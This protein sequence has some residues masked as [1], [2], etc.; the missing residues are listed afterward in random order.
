MIDSSR[1]Y[2]SPK[3]TLTRIHSG[4]RSRRPRPVPTPASAK[5]PRR[6]TVVSP[7]D[8]L[9][10]APAPPPRE[11]TL[12]SSGRTRHATS[13][14]VKVAPP[15]RA[16]RS[17]GDRVDDFVHR[18]VDALARERRDG[19]AAN[20]TRHDPVEVPHVGVDV[21]REAVHR[22]TAGQSH[23]DRRNLAGIIGL[24]VDPHAGIVAQATDVGETEVPE[25]IDDE[26]LDRADIRDGVGHAASALA[27]HPQHWIADELARPVIGDITAAVRDHEL[28]ADLGRFDQDIGAI[29][30][31][32][33]RVHV[34]VFEQ[35]Q[36]VG[37]RSREESV[38][39]LQRVVV[40]DRPEPTDVQRLDEGA[41]R[42]ALHP[43][44]AFR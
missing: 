36:V 32:A 6:R 41:L 43:N 33:E 9:S 7:L 10:G 1:R 12:R 38:L 11:K 15:Q 14:R 22:S 24:G 34:R 19:L 5:R 27:R 39:Q 2:S 35:Q 28:C 25:G 26:L 21:E 8:R 17:I 30:A 20:A 23:T 42:R 3:L 37:R 16:R 4:L 31:N 29:G 13:A 18:G 44:R 40:V